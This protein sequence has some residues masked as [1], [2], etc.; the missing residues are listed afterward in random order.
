MFVDERS[1]DVERSRGTDGLITSGDKLLF[2]RY[3]QVVRPRTHCIWFWAVDKWRLSLA[4]GR[5]GFL[6]AFGHFLVQS[7]S[8]TRCHLHFFDNPVVRALVQ[9]LVR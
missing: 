5:F 7:S 2:S 6:L 4:R 8:D 3:L 1:G 9:L